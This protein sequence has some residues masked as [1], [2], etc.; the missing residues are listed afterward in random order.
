MNATVPQIRLYVSLDPKLFLRIDGLFL[1]NRIY[2]TCQR[3]SNM[4]NSVFT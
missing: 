1:G 2:T 4:T 3:S